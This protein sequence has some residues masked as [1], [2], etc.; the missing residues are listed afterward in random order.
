MEEQPIS[1]RSCI[2]EIA[3]DYTK[4]KHVFRVMT[5][6]GSEFLFQ[7]DDRDTM[8]SWIKAI[9][10]NSHPDMDVSGLEFLEFLNVKNNH[11]EAKN[12]TVSSFDNKA[13]LPWFGGSKRLHTT[14][15]VELS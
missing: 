15:A 6:H 9:Q 8:L 1:V 14:E 4:K 10:Y 3:H 11:S 5:S 13:A 2:V 12:W 7:A